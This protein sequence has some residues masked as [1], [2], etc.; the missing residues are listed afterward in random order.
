MNFRKTLTHYQNQPEIKTK[1]IT[2]PLNQ[3]NEKKLL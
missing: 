1:I 2:K 3:L